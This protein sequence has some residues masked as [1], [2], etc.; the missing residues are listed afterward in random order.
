LRRDSARLVARP[1]AE[2]TSQEVDALAGDDG[3]NGDEQDALG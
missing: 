2:R 3:G 1:L